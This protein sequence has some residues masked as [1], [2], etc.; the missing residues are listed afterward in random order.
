MQIEIEEYLFNQEGLVFLDE[1]FNLGLN[2][3]HIQTGFLLGHLEEDEEWIQIIIE[4]QILEELRI[5]ELHLGAMLVI[6]KEKHPPIE[7]KCPK[8]VLLQHK[9]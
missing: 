1:V 8:Q 4:E 9:C 2:Q 7:H 5:E 6:S 3:I